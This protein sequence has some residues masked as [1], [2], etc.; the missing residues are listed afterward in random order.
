MAAVPGLRV[1]TVPMLSTAAT[2]ESELLQTVGTPISAL[3]RGSVAVTAK[4][5]VSP[6]EVAV[7][8]AGVTPT[9]RTAARPLTA[10]ESGSN[11]AFIECV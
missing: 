10:T 1:T 3:P 9:H 6:T 2:I 5:I 7:S 4:L 8:N 11:L